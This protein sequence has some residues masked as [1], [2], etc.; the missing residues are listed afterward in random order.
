MAN[1]SSGHRKVYEELIAEGLIGVDE[2]GKG[3]YFGPLVCAACFLNSELHNPLKREKIK[4]SKHLSNNRVREIARLIKETC[5]Y[6]IIAIGPAKYNQLYQEIKNL[7]RLLAWAHAK[8]IENLLG[9]TNC[10]HVLTD[11]FGSERLVLKALQEKGRKVNLIQQPKAEQNPAVA[12]ASILARAE[13]LARLESL[14]QAF[15]IDLQPG[16]GPPT[17][18]VARKFLAKHGRDKLPLVA[19]MH[20]KNTRKVLS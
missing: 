6:D 14:S 12:A 17:D 7:N 20:F 10:K 2:A 5:P 9:K 15:G 18:R 4:D 16:A 8:A 3:D 19:K 11:Q 13:F 1:I